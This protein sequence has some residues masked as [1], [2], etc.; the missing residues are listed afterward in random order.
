MLLALALLQAIVAAPPPAGTPQPP[1]TIF[2]EPAALFIAACDANG[3]G[4]VTQ[5]ELTAGIVR[6]YATAE[7]AASGSI[8][9]I[10]FADWAQAW[11][12]DRNALPSPFEVDRDGDNRITLVE[13]QARFSQFFARFDRDKD[14]VLTRAELITI[15]GAPAGDRYGIRKKK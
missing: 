3:D 7:G 9:Y 1:A 8:G 6:S 15:R 4:R 5:A 12:G 10:A 11:L 14:G 13:L 2:A